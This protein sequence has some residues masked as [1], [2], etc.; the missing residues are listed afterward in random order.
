MY[1]RESVGPR[2]MP[3]GTLALI[4]GYFCEDFPSEAV[5][6]WKSWNKSKYQICNSIRFEFVKKASM[7]N[8]VKSYG[9][10]KCSCYPI[11]CIYQIATDFLPAVEWEYLKF[12]WKQQ[13]RLHFLKWSFASFS[14]I[15]LTTERKLTWQ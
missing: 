10:I 7:S 13:R 15:S 6:Y 8:L 9:P 2:I 5:Y 3:W 1:S 12:Y 14:T 4:T 11:K